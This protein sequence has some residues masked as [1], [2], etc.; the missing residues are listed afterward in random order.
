MLNNHGGG[1]F[2][3]IAGPNQLATRERETYFLTPQRLN[4]KNTAMDHGCD[5]HFAN[6]DASLAT[7]LD[8]FFEPSTQPRILEVET[9]RAVNGS[10]FEAFKALVR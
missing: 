4:A 2:D 3:L 7:A 6:D 9:D 5:Y 10:V 8:G 1:I